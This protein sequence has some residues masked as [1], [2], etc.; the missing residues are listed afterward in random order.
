MPGVHVVIGIMFTSD[1][2]HTLPIPQLAESE[3]VTGKPM[4]AFGAVHD[5][6][7]DMG[8]TQQ[9]CGGWHVAI[10][11]CT[12]PTEPPSVGPE[13]TWLPPSAAPASPDAESP[14]LVSTVF[15]SMVPP[16]SS[17]VWTVEP[18]QAHAV[19]AAAVSA[20]ATT[21][22]FRID[23]I[24]APPLPPKDARTL[25]QKGSLR[26]LSRRLVAVTARIRSDDGRHP[27][28]RFF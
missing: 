11:Q 6:L 22:K 20:H 16:P 3:H 10:P 4:Q 27:C 12:G 28:C 13:S 23:R 25:A 18:P 14:A 5:A 1:P 7:I 15:A 2:Q 9:T 24:E 17:P 26:G 19:A 21:K 8:S